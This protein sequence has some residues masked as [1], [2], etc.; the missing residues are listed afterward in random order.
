ME[1]S[2]AVGLEGIS[3]KQLSGAVSQDSGRMAEG[4]DSF[5]LEG[6]ILLITVDEVGNQDEFWDVSDTGG[7]AVQ[8][9]QTPLYQR[10]GE[11]G[12]NVARSEQALPFSTNPL[13]ARRDTDEWRDVDYW[14]LLQH[15]AHS[16]SW[17]DTGGWL[18]RCS[19]LSKVLRSAKAEPVRN[20]SEP[21]LSSVLKSAKMAGWQNQVGL[22]GRKD[23]VGQPLKSAP[24]M[25][26]KAPAL[27]PDTPRFV[28]PWAVDRR[29]FPSY[30]Q[31]QDVLGFFTLFE[32]TCQDIGLQARHYMLI[33]RSQISGVLADLLGTMSGAAALDYQKFKELALKRFALSAESYHRAFRKAERHAFPDNYPV[34]AAGLAQNLNHWLSAEKVYIY[35]TL[36]ELMLMEQFYRLLSN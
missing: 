17:N 5:S 12:R 34:A 23:A 20:P 14:G 36:R 6:E 35:T 8:P 15:S 27:A 29:M 9:K 10:E 21:E 2:I 33:L 18:P 26:S 4:G 1:H 28:A 7:P 24:Q 13:S 30:K 31:G 16:N 32:H 3:A 25:D 19:E 22:P 11:R